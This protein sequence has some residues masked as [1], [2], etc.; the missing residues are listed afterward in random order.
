MSL[1]R[2][3]SGQKGGARLKK[4]RARP[5]ILVTGFGPF[6]DTPFNASQ[7]LVEDLRG[8]KADSDQKAEIFTAILPTN[9]RQ[10]PVRTVSLIGDIKPDVVLHLGVSSRANG[11]EIE[12][13]AF[14]V[15]C[16]A[17]DC[18]GSYPPGHYVRRGGP[19]ILKTMLPAK[20]LLLKLRLAGVP[21]SLSP[22]AG[23][24]LCNAVLYESL[25]Q[26]KR[27]PNAPFT[28]FIHIPALSAHQPDGQEIPSTVCGPA[29][30]KTGLD[31]IIDT[32]IPFVR[33]MF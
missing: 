29:K 23:R 27:M 2:G 6:P 31:V 5:R 33:N 9:W 15:T 30:L 3:T 4:G 28:G 25:F 26:A 32:M 21:A 1:D 7:A 13:R 18:T 11:L 22:D 14:N 12:T 20:R 19:P 17:P 10:A 16:C 8:D 24:Y